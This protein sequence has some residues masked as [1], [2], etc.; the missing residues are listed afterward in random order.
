[1]PKRAKV[2]SPLP[3]PPFAPDAKC[4]A[5]PL[6]PKPNYWSNMSTRNG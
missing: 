1:M 4:M 5:I 2:I 3:K 6:N